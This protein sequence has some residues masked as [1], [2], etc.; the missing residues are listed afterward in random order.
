VL[1]T[2]STCRRPWLEVAEEAILG[3]ADCLQ[4]REKEM[5]GGELL[6]RARQLVALCR[7]HDVLCLIND[8]PDIASLSDADGVHV[9]QSDLPA[10]E[11]RKLI[12]PDKILGVSTH[13]I[14]QARQAVL[15][16]AD[17]I[18]V[19]PVFRSPTKPRDILPGLDYVRQVADAI[20]LPAV[21]I[22]GIT[23]ENAPQ[24]LAAGLNR[25]AVTAA[26]AG[27][28]DPRGAAKVLKKLLTAPPGGDRPAARQ[29]KTG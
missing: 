12:G 8:R 27:C 24:V 19:G 22:A 28:A 9:G 4:L 26:V 15:D 11:V 1:I 17:Y 29:E 21:A 16:G 10:A 5:E 13:R 14:E 25:L 7:R 2:E 3:G 23:S 20:P 6:S 18:G